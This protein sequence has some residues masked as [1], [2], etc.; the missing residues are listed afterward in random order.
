MKKLVINKQDLMFSS[1]D[2][3]RIY[4]PLLMETL[5]NAT[6]GI[7]DTM[8]VARAGEAAV[9]GVSCFNTIQNLMIALFMAFGTGGA[10]VVGQ[11]IG[12]RNKERASYAS[13]QL[14]YLT[15]TVSL[16]LAGVF[17]V[18]RE[19][20]LHMVYGTIEED[21]FRSA[22]LY[23]IPILISLPFM[24]SMSALNALF[25]AMGKTKI[26]MDVSIIANVVNVIGNAFCIIVLHWGAFGVGFATLLSRVVASLILFVRITDKKLPVRIN[27]IL[28]FEPDLKMM[29]T[30]LRIALPS[31]LENSIFHLGKIVMISTIAYCGT[32]S[33]AAFAV[34]DNIGTFSNMSGQAA[35]L[36]MLTLCGQCCG[37]K[38][39]DQARY[40]AW[41]LLK[42]TYLSML[43]VAIVLA[44]IMPFVVSIY[45]YGEETYR[46]TVQVCLEYLVY[47]TLF[48]PM[49][50]TLPSALKAAGDVNFTMIASISSMWLFRV[51]FARFLGITLGMG[52]RGALLGMYIDWIVRGTLFLL[53]FRS[54]KWETK[55]IDRA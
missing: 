33:I 23:A 31:G 49:S 51:F 37:A 17:M 5:L 7:A 26:T 6:V 9:S 39:Y 3:R 55:G 43:S 36:S 20:I 12:M 4:I 14:L 29:S 34:L 40:Y 11:L 19:P 8:M 52:L 53:R 30:I 46:L 24:A 50:F 28:K 22:S 16:V 27:Q 21:V 35:N 10:V 45:G 41:L 25:R 44:I 18:I 47:S 48:W 13:K 32:P 15:L 42:I 1:V 54:G 2:V 38:E